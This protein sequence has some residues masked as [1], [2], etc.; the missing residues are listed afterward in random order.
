LWKIF[1]TFGACQIQ[2][3]FLQ[4]SGF[5][6]HKTSQKTVK[7]I[8]SYVKLMFQ[9]LKSIS[10][11][12]EQKSD[13]R[14]QNTVKQKQGRAFGPQTRSGLHFYFCARVFFLVMMRESC[15]SKL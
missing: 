13:Y 5:C 8:Q 4:K 11:K 1:T 12:Y 15:E 2:D 10:I 14:K 9:L 3:R 6:N 7:H